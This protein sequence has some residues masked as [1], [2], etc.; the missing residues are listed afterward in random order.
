M[1]DWIK[2][3]L[4]I[5]QFGLV[6]VIGRCFANQEQRQPLSVKFRRE[7]AEEFRED[8]QKLSRILKRDLINWC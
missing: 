1:F 8:I 6:A 4:D 5:E 2:R 3:I 7:L